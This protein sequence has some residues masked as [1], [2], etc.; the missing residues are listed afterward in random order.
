[1]TPMDTVAQYRRWFAY[2]KDAHDRVLS[3]FATVPTAKRAAKE[4]QK[5]L[6]LFSHM[7]AARR[8]W[9]Y[10]FGVLPSLPDGLFA[11][12]KSLDQVTED[13]ADVHS[14]WDRYFEGLDAAEASR[15]FEYTATDGHRYRNT[16]EEI[17]AQ[18]FG[19]SWYH[20]GQIALLIKMLGGTPAETD[21][22]LRTRERV[23]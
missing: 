18:L 23:T 14:A 9:L 11:E 21:Y 17:L 6:D 13:I 1:M 5:A 20:R 10:R 2:E 19:H 3:S 12:G 15:V 7:I 4:F 16:I 8:M 22:V